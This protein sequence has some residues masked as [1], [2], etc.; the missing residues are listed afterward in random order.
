MAHQLARVMTMD[1]L[2]EQLHERYLSTHFSGLRS[3][4]TDGVESYARHYRRVYAPVLPADKSARILDVGCGLGHFLY[5]LKT[6][7]YVHHWG[8]DLGG[9]QIRHCQEKITPQVERVSNTT[10]YLEERTEQFDAIVFIDVLEHL[11][12]DELWQVLSA[13][14]DALT[15]GG[16][17]IVSVPN[18]ACLTALMT[19]YGD[20]THRRLFT[21]WS[22][23]QL[24]RVV[25][26]RDIEMFPNEKKVIRSFRS[27]RERWLWQLRD[28]FIRWLL[29][30]FYRHLM[31]GAIPRIQTINLLATAKSPG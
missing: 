3:V 9:E 20:L 15:P 5:F 10:A 27:R 18:A 11:A 22:M 26:F 25:G 13:T 7:G 31:E 19:R 28:K 4:H 8:I 30:E 17:L 14:K 21:E 6:E 29:A 16:R 23:G 1:Q 2:Q 24:L 12:D